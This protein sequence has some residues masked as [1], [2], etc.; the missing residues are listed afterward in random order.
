M[1]HDPF[2]NQILSR[3]NGKLDPDV[4]EA[5]AVEL[6]RLD[7]YAAVPVLGGDD[8]GMDGAIADGQ[9]EPFPLVTTTS[10]NCIGNLT[11]N[12]KQYVD[13][14]G[15]RRKVVFATSQALTSQKQRNLYQ[16]AGELGFTLSQL[17]ERSAIAARLYRNPAWCRELLQLTGTP[18]ALS[19]IPLTRR[20]FL[21]NELIGREEAL[22]W[23]QQTTGDR[24]LAGEPGSGKTSLLYRLT[25]TRAALFVVSKDMSS[26]ANAIREQEPQHIIVDDAH[27]DPDFLISLKRLRTEI[28]AEFDIIA[29]CWTGEIST[30]A[31]ILNLADT[32][33]YTLRR[34][35]RD[36]MVDVI[37]AAGIRGVNWL[38]REIVT[39]AE[40]LPGLAVT[41]THL[42]LQGSIERIQTADALSSTILDFYVKRVESHVQ[43]ILASFAL[44]GDAGMPKL[45]VGQEL[46]TPFPKLRKVLAEL[47]TGGV[48]A[49]VDFTGDRLKVRPSAFRHA[50][51]RET[52][53]SGASAL[54][55]STLNNLL[56]QTPDLIE[57]AQDLIHVKARGG[58][59]PDYLLQEYLS[60][61]PTV[62]KVW[63]AYAW[64]GPAE[65]TWVL[66]HFQGAAADIA[67]PILT[68]APQR[69]ISALISE[70]VGDDRLL[71]ATPE[72]PLRRLED[73]IHE[74][75]PG[76]DQA[77]GRR[78]LLFE[79]A[80]RWLLD[81]N[82][83]AIGYTALLYA[84]DPKFESH[85]SDPGSGN[86]I[87]LRSAYLTATELTELQTVWYHTL[88]LTEEIPVSDWQPFIDIIRDWAYPYRN[89]SED[90]GEIMRD[91]AKQMALSLVE[92]TDGQVSIVY[93]LRR[94]LES[95]LSEF[96]VDIDPE[97]D[98]LYPQ[99]RHTEDWRDEESKW[100]KG[101]TDLAIQWQERFPEI[102]VH[103]LEEIENQMADANYRYP[104]LTP[105]LAHKLAQHT[106]EPLQYVNAILGTNLSGDILF[107]F[108]NKAV[109]EAYVGW[110]LAAETCFGD[111]RFCGTTTEI[112]LKLEKPPE[113]LL[114]QALQ[115]LSQFPRLGELL[116]LRNELPETLLPT[117]L[118]HPDVSVAQAAALAEWHSDP[119]GTVRDWLRP[120][121]ERAI[122][123]HC[124]DDYWLGEIFKC[125]RHLAF[126][127]LESRI[128]TDEFEVYRFD[129]AIAAAISGLEQSERRRLLE[130]IPDRYG[131]HD[132]VAQLV[133][134]DLELFSYLLAS[135]RLED[136]YLAPIAGDIDKAWC[137]KAKLAYN[138]GYSAQEIA[139]RTMMPTGVVV[140]WGGKE[141]ERYKGWLKKFSELHDSDDDTIRTI[142]L[143]GSNICREQYQRALHREYLEDVYGID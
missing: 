107:P 129:R 12:L 29:T 20:P 14:G 112:I 51:I 92:R 53:F 48:I 50:L 35:S 31:D 3:L 139:A 46:D 27:V 38:V 10:N 28:A 137:G 120:A 126:A 111:Q 6:V 121:W 40:G 60:A 90:A 54:P 93:S 23:L 8:A 2:F 106:N 72:H 59:V 37:A 89:Y 104:R 80:K 102:N 62:S 71:N 95:P 113:H 1:K 13:K 141:S 91:F 32:H 136:F 67:Y 103:R 52:F 58:N 135:K 63:T 76:S 125:E 97:I 115:M 45:V 140:T 64:L 132:V 49:E 39:Q 124:T 61:L 44:G 74:P 9:G 34:L 83:A 57:T 134:D 85:T 68:N 77:I 108:L 65:A 105:A 101:V 118:Q 15:K 21:N 73:W 100:Q 88:E 114:Q 142:G 69:A 99:E 33:I 36:Q 66:E 82:D 24:L 122:V 109:N 117:L 119:K 25:Q 130:I 17:Y 5:C 133:A 19:V 116:Y 26:I 138:A 55:I 41:L 131:Y 47:A 75:Y 81:M 30:I 70:A 143:A 4:F 42:C 128:K 87:T 127:W 16:R 56:Q 22:D 11:R 94:V 78:R 79:R 98:I 86:T 18:S 123:D 84:L 96:P 43:E 7:G 110:E